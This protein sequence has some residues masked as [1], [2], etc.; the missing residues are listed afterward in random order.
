MK[1]VTAQFINPVTNIK[2]DISVC[3]PVKEGSE[4]DNALL[5][6]GIKLNDLTIISRH[7]VSVE[8][9]ANAEIISG[10]VKEGSLIV[11]IV[12]YDC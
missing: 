1:R 5:R 6:F 2:Q 8:N 12:I 7:S 3:E 10:I 4:I 9:I 11:T